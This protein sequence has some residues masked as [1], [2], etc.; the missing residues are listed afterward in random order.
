MMRRNAVPHWFFPAHAPTRRVPDDLRPWLAD[1]ASLT[2]R[3]RAVSGRL[4]VE[5][6]GQG[7]GLALL[8]E[9]DLLALPTQRR[10]LV[11]EVML[12]CDGVA[13]VFARTV[14]PRNTLVGRY[15]R[16]LA[17]G[18]RPLGEVLF[19]D[20]TISRGAMQAACLL[21]AHHLY[22][23]AAAQMDWQ[24]PVLWARRSVFYL[25]GR[26]LLVNEVFLPSLLFAGRG[27]V[28]SMA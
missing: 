11:R 1:P 5:V 16:L 27:Y 10:M 25:S 21:P 28:R 17:L 12:Y 7:A 19:R 20:R 2:A 23:L 18:E 8:D 24:P 4:Q 6:L 15:R 14:V 3:L 13:S 22:Q 26:P 9:T